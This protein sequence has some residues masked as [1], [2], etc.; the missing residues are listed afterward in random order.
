MAT[1]AVMYPLPGELAEWIAG[2]AGREDIEPE[3]LLRRCVERERR[4]LTPD[5]PQV[6]AR[7]KRVGVTGP[8]AR[9]AA[10]EWMG[11]DVAAAAGCSPATVSN[12]LKQGAI[13]CSEQGTQGK[14]TRF[15]HDQA[16]AALVVLAVREFSIPTTLQREVFDL[17][18]EAGDKLCLPGRFLVIGSATV[19][20]CA[21]DWLAQRIVEAGGRAAVLHL[22]DF[23][24]VAKAAA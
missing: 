15:S 17:I 18:V 7:T 9:L 22:G 24:T 8:R 20:V 19:V 1:I 3:A 13:S 14:V 21:R 11:A 16:R 4:R 2:Q 6:D 23:A 12:A 10:G 5:A